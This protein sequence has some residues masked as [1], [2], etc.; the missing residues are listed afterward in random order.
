[1]VYTMD[2]FAVLRKFFI[3]VAVVSGSLWGA[4]QTGILHYGPHASTILASVA[5]GGAA[6]MPSLLP[7]P[8]NDAKP[9]APP[10]V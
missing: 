1:M 2:K 8:A 3:A 10:A 5:I 4:V 7:R 9:P 6:L